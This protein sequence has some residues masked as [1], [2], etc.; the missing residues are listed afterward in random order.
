VTDPTVDLNVRITV[1]EV[2]VKDTEEVTS[3]TWPSVR[4]EDVDFT[5]AMVHLRGKKPE[6]GR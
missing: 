5:D 3:V 4:H 6:G 1:R 2:G